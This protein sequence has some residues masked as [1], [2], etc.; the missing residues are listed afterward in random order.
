MA[1]DPELIGANV[2]ETENL[3]AHAVGPDNAIELFHVPPLRIGAA[4]R[5][6]IEGNG[7]QIDLADIEKKCRGHGTIGQKRSRESSRTVRISGPPEKSKGDQRGR[8]NSI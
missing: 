4:N 5:C 7:V 3:S 2:L 1:F 8:P 6:L